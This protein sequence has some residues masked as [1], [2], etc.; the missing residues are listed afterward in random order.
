MTA[1]RSILFLLAAA[2]SGHVLHAAGDRQ[3][4]P[5]R[6]TAA[7]AGITTHPYGKTAEGHAVTMFALTNAN[8]LELR[9][10]TYGGIIT[11]LT[12][13]DRSGAMGDI[14][15][16]F[17]RLEEYFKDSPYFGA[18]V[19]RYG[20]RIAGGRFTLDGRGYTLAKNNGPNHLHGGQKGF[21]KVVWKAV[22]S[23]SGA[24]VTFSRTSPDGEEGYPGNLQVRVSYTLTD[25]NELI[26]DTTPRRTRRRRS[27]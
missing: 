16:G 23:T 21:D 25:G 12:V 1:R 27:T 3:T 8:G 17:G 9:A 26:I 22:P 10:M 11:S 13:P 15:L 14:V 24:A 20:N 6:T 4:P 7:R 18:I 19:G 5:P 2:M